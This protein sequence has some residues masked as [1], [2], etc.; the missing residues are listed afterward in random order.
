MSEDPR[1]VAALQATPVTAGTEPQPGWYVVT[2][3]SGRVMCIRRGE[4]GDKNRYWDIGESPVSLAPD[5][6]LG[7]RVDDLLRDAAEAKRLREIVNTIVPMAG[8]FDPDNEEQ[9]EEI[10]LEWSRRYHV[11]KR[12]A[13]RYRRIR[14]AGDRILTLMSRCSD[15][16]TED[17][18]SEYARFVASLQSIWNNALIDAE[19]AREEKDSGH[20]K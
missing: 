20:E 12:D 15:Q 7:P 14:D 3:P 1:L 9:V 18:A 6:I 11:A 5:W 8:C 19:I 17:Q 4:W 13:A 2:A 16:V 10:G